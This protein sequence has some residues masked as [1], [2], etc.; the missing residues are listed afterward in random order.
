M[1]TWDV[2]LVEQVPEP[3]EGAEADTWD[4]WFRY[5]ADADTYVALH[6]CDPYP[7]LNETCATLRVPV[8]E[9]DSKLGYPLGPGEKP[10]FNNDLL[11]AFAYT[12]LALGTLGKPLRNQ[13]YILDLPAFNQGFPYFKKFAMLSGIPILPKL[14]SIEGTGRTLAIAIGI[15]LAPF[16]V[17]WAILFLVVIITPCMVLLFFRY[18]VRLSRFA[19][20]LTLL[21]TSIFGLTMTIIPLVYLG[22]LNER[23]RYALVYQ[24]QN[25]SPGECYCG[26][27]YFINAASLIRISAIGAGVTFS[28][29]L[30]AFRCLKGLRRA[31]WANLMPR[32][33]GKG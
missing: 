16:I 32:G 18:P 33:T 28:S 3:D 14:F 4:R 23:P 26:C 12:F 24:I 2:V 27:S 7:T 17:V 6:T 19:V 1:Q 5:Q 20:F 8:Y 13:N 29:C 22:N 25:Y 10:S 11:Y 31:Q 21:A 15:I 9:F 30:S